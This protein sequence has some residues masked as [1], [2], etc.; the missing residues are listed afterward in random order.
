MIGAEKGENYAPTAHLKETGL[1]VTVV[2]LLGVMVGPS[3]TV[4][5]A[6]GVATVRASLVAPTHPP[7]TPPWR[8]HPL[9]IVGE[10][11]FF[12]P[13]WEAWKGFLNL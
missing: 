1:V 8:R 6:G 10:R 12:N 9:Y 3:R 4:A 11:E 2:V 13:L 5:V 7:A